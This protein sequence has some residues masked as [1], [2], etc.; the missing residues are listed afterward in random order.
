MMKEISKIDG[1]QS[2]KIIA[3][4]GF[5]I[6][7]IF[8]VIGLIAMLAGSATGA[9][10]YEYFGWAYLLLTLLYV[11]IVYLVMRF[12]FWVYNKYAARWGGILIDMTD[13][14]SL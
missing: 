1:K 13:K 3:I 5:F 7:L 10:G 11:P 9:V 2:A 4:T 14:E 6:M 12:Y 8:A